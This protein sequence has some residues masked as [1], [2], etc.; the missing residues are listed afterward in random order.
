MVAASIVLGVVGLGLLY[1]ATRRS[2]YG[3]LVAAIPLAGFIVIGTTGF[4][5]TQMDAERGEG[6]AV[7]IDD[8]GLFDKLFY[9]QVGHFTAP[10][11]TRG[12]G[13]H[14]DGPVTDIAQAVGAAGGEHLGEHIAGHR[15]GALA[16]P[17]PRCRADG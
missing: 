15:L 2:G 14:Q 11:P 9:A 7:L 10:A 13:H 3:L 5:A 8:W 17:W 1:G 16:F 12:K 6:R 4:G